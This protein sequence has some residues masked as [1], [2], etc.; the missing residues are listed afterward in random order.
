MIDDDLTFHRHELGGVVIHETLLPAKS[1]GPTGTPTAHRRVTGGR[2]GSLG[3][4]GSIVFDQHA[5]G[6]GNRYFFLLQ[7]AN[8][9]HIVLNGG[10]KDVHAAEQAAIGIK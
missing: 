9:I 5:A 10:G 3:G 8:L 6:N 1:G 2:C 7:R 4:R